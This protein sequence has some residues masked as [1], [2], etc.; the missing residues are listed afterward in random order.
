MAPSLVGKGL[1][2]D[3]PTGQGVLPQ[4]VITMKIEI[5]NLLSLEGRG[6]RDAIDATESFKLTLVLHARVDER[7]K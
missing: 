7:R 5:W 3:V 4:S 2:E 6:L 1:F